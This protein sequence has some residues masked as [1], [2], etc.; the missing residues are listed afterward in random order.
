MKKKAGVPATSLDLVRSLHACGVQQVQRGPGDLPGRLGAA[1]DLHRQQLVAPRPALVLRLASVD[2]LRLLSSKV[3]ETES[4]GTCQ[5][6]RSLSRWLPLAQHVYACTSRVLS[7]HP[8][9]STPAPL[10]KMN[11]T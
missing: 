11:S 10:P 6:S 3:G 5:T 2:Q 4:E 8:P 1:K 9:P 7:H